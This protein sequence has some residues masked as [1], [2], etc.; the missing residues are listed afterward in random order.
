MDTLILSAGAPPTS[1]KFE[2]LDL[3]FDEGT[4][5]DV[6]REKNNKTVAE[7]ISHARYQKLGMIVPKDYADYLDTPLGRF[8][9]ELK[10][11]SD[12]FYKRFLNRY[13]DSAYSRFYIPT[14][15]AL[16]QKGIYCY[17][18]S[19]NLKYIGRC[20]DSLKKR[21]NQGYGKIHPKNCY[22][23]G[24]A[25]NCHLNAL[26]TEVAKEVE[27]WFCELDID[28]INE[29]EKDLIAEYKPEWNIQGKV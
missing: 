6:F 28:D 2:K 15:S 12:E 11:S 10:D 5:A 9:G 3:T 22:I 25:T 24:Q 26:I 27:F 4:F 8:L 7:T 16:T 14:E 18:V 17:S 23:D 19:G 21:I 29:A 20:R 1:Y 13:G